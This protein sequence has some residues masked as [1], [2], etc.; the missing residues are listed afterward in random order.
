M[1]YVVKDEHSE[2]VHWCRI[3]KDILYLVNLQIP[4]KQ[5]SFELMLTEIYPRL[6]PKLSLLNTCIYRNTAQK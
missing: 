1:V 3:R 2:T 5:G 6:T 4:F